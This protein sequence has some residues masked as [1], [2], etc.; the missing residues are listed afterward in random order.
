[1][2]NTLQINEQD[3]AKEVPALV[4]E[5]EKFVVTNDAQYHEAVERA[6]V[7]KT[8]LQTVVDFF[9][10]MKKRAHEAWKEVCSKENQFVPALELSKKLYTQKAADYQ[11]KK[12]REQEEKERAAFAAAQKK[13][14]E[15]K[16]KL[17]A[18]AKAAEEAGNR[19]K[20]EELREKVENV[21]VAPRAVQQAPRAQGLSVQTVWEPQV[22]NEDL[23]P[24]KWYKEIDLV[25]MKKAKALDKTLEIPGIKFVERAQGAARTVSTR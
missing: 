23:I 9:A 3:L 1:M 2:E 14:D 21:Y 12:Q 20:A 22:V 5:A 19:E 24:K 16:A 10:P 15:K 7:C 4:Q 13:E 17:E 6:N 18:D 11:L 25:R 8:K